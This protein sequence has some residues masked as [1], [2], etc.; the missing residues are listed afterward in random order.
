MRDLMDDWKGASMGALEDWRKAIGGRDKQ[1]KTFLSL[2]PEDIT[3]IKQEYGAESLQAYV[4]E[5]RRRLENG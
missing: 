1:V 5:M 4:D 2:K 3:W